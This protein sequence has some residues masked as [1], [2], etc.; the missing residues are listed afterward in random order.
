M[1]KLDALCLF[2]LAEHLKEDIESAS[3]VIK[4]LQAYQE[5]KLCRGI[6]FSLISDLFERRDELSKQE[7]FE[8]ML[9]SIED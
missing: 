6:A 3:P 7:I 1:K 8:R 4:R 9:A 2:T 5:C